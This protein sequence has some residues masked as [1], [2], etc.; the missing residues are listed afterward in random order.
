MAEYE[1]GYEDEK[2]EHVV[3]ESF[4]CIIC[5]NVFKDPVMCSQNEH[6]FCRGCITQ[7]L[8]N[9]PTCPTCMEPLTL[10]TLNQA[11]RSL[12]N[13]LAELRIRCDFFERGCG[14]FIELGRLEIHAKDCGFAPA[15]CPNVECQLVVNKQDLAR[16]E[17]GGCELRGVFQGI[18]QDMDEV[19]INL[20]FLNEKLA[21]HEKTMDRN[22]RNLK[23]MEENLAAKVEGIQR[24]LNKQEVNSGNVQRD[25]IKMKDSLR[26]IT[27]QLGRMMQ[28]S[29]LH[30]AVVEQEPRVVISGGHDNDSALNSVEMFK[31]SAETWTQLQPMR[32]SS[33]EVSSV[34][35]ND[36]IFAVRGTCMEN[37]PIDGVHDV[38]SIAWETRVSKLAI[39]LDGRCSVVCRGRLIVIGGYN[40]EENTCSDSIMEISLVPPF[41]IKRLATMPQKRCYHGVAVFDR[42]IL[43]VGGSKNGWNY[44]PISNV[45][46]YD[47]EKNKFQELAP[48]PYPVSEMATVKWGE[49]NVIVMGGLDSNAEPLNSVLLYNVRTQKSHVLPDMKCKRYGC[50]GAVM[51]DTVIVMGGKDVNYDSLKSV[52]CFRFSQYAWKNLPEMHEARCWAS[53]VVC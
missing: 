13:L 24:Q 9:Y 20:A 15:V 6:V 52:E 17:A 23:A 11:P 43:I 30:E 12:R 18:K 28:P 7:H 34:V 45:V 31:L 2:F 46:M 44:S 3:S 16:H 29:L 41:G 47:I 39:D 19:K 32:E 40:M 51:G 25:I 26:E 10:E 35:Y 53:A 14:K 21:A 50:A 27:K 38:E 1:T 5:T 22:D 36:Q 8:G 4:H 33:G 42:K 49:D 37:L 48:L